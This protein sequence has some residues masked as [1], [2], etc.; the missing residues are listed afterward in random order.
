MKGTLIR[1]KQ[2]YNFAVSFSFSVLS[3]LQHFLLDFLQHEDDFLHFFPFPPS[4]AIA[5]PPIIKAVVANKNNFFI[6][7]YLFFVINQRKNKRIIAYCQYGVVKIPSTASFY[8]L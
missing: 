8:S 1:L 3:F 7:V 2:Y 6:R 5:T 4:A